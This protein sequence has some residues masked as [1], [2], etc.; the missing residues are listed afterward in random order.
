[1]WGVTSIGTTLVHA[2]RMLTVGGY[3]KKTTFR[4]EHNLASDVFTVGSSLLPPFVT[5]PFSAMCAA[6]LH[7]RPVASA[8]TAI[9][10]TSAFYLVFCRK[11]RARCRRFRPE[12]LKGCPTF[13]ALPSVDASKNDAEPLPPNAS[14]VR[15]LPCPP[16]F[17]LCF[18]FVCRC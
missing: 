17:A 12:P 4:Y 7:A 14:H 18:S 8:G 11:S 10:L 9:A 5:L 13:K 2:L 3:G 6:R 1:M 16:C 15:P